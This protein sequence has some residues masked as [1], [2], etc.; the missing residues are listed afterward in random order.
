[1]GWLWGSVTKIKGDRARLS[2]LVSLRHGHLLR[3]CPEQLLTPAPLLRPDRLHNLRTRLSRPVGQS[4]IAGARSLDTR[5]PDRGM[6][7]VEIPGCGH[8]LARRTPIE[9]G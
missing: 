3:L 2:A 9:Y 8:V 1:M 6:S 4:Y 7:A 5:N